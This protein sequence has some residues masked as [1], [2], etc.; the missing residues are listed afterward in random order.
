MKA[1][2]FGAGSIGRGFIGDLLHDSGYQIVFID[3]NA[4]LA[5]Q[6]NKTGSYD[7]YLVD[8]NYKKKT[9]NQV[10]ALSPLTQKEQV[11]AAI[12]DADL[13]TTS[14]WAD[15]LAKIAPVLHLGLLARKAKNRPKVN[16]VVCENAMENGDILLA[17]LLKCQPSVTK[18]EL[19]QLACFP[20]TAVDRLVLNS[21]RDGNDTIDIGRDFELVIEKHKLVDSTDEPIKGAEYTDNLSKYL[22]RKLYVIN[23]GHAWA[24]YIGYVYGY[25]IIQDVF[26]DQKLVGQVKETMREV[27]QLLVKQYQFDYQELLDYIDFAVNRFQT[28][29]IV[30]TINRVCRSPIRKLAPQDRLVGPAVLCEQYQCDNHFIIKGIAAAFLFFNADDQQCIELKQYIEQN[31]IEKAITHYTAIKPEASM[32]QQILQN[33][34]ELKAIKQ[35]H[36][37]DG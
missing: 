4:Q 14:V 26:N 22:A 15:N 12:C 13:I 18:S 23:G 34:Y 1:I 2:H 31:S 37:H 30:D 10:S 35:Q 3:V 17:E 24:G 16:V 19:N 5:E 21:H 32:Y 6:M 25:D 9:I 27:A 33:Y 29:G 28:P 8:E 20:N 11:I 7:L 36:R